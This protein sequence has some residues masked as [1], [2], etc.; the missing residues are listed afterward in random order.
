MMSICEMSLKTA[1]LK[2]LSHLPG[3]NGR[4]ILGHKLIIGYIYNIN[5]NGNDNDNESNFTPMN[6]I[7]LIIGDI[8]A[9]PWISNKL[10]FLYIYLHSGIINTFLRISVYDRKNKIMLHYSIPTCSY[11]IHDKGRKEAW[12]Y[13]P[14]YLLKWNRIYG[15]VQ[16]NKENAQ[17]QN[18]V[19][20][21]GT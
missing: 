3:A 10:V 9:S 15:G 1:C 21:V 12:A 11:S 16:K 8:K 6:Y 7:N 17:A 19:C 13:K 20:N 18:T 4:W 5:D 14:Q 2:L